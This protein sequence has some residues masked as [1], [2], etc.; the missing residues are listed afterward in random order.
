M[1][2]TLQ[3]EFPFRIFYKIGEASKIVGVEPYVLR[4]WEK[5]F[6]FLKPKKTKTG[7]RLYTKKEIDMLL[8]IKRMLYDEGYT[9]EGV[10][11][12][13]NKIYKKEIDSA[14]EVIQRVKKRLTEILKIL[15]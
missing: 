2:Q 13:F 5:E 9:I 3:G 12:N 11:K 10:R 7:Q 4:F 14:E 6:P 1:K 15:S 8:S